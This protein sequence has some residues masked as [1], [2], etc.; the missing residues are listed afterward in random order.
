L[1]K[2]HYIL[3]SI[4]KI[5]ARTQ[6]DCKD[7]PYHLEV[8]DHLVDLQR[9]GLVRSVSGKNFPPTMLRSIHGCGFRLDSHQMDCNLLTNPNPWNAEHRSAASDLELPT[10]FSNPLAGGLLTNRFENQL[11]P[12]LESELETATSHEQ[13]SRSLWKW[14]LARS[15]KP[16]D[17]PSS[18]KQQ[19]FWT[20]NQYQNNLLPVLY[21]IA[22]KYEVG[23]ATVALRWLYQM[24]QARGVV[25]GCNLMVDPDDIRKE[26]E[27][28]QRIKSWRK[29]FTFEL[30]KDDIES[31]N[32]IGGSGLDRS[33]EDDM[34][35][36]DMMRNKKLWL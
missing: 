3:I 14:A 19:D 11:F 12:P 13:L 8:M 32:E 26:R 7:S 18:K 4:R 20:W 29:T 35:I 36:N 28:R 6:T 22:R 21:D 2:L 23:V 5:N 9:D 30:D 1:R 15:K 16:N 10:L 27:I 33:L 34:N 24:D 25:V 31:I 17:V